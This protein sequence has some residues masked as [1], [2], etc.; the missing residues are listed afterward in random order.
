MNVELQELLD[1]TQEQQDKW[2]RW[3]AEK[4]DAPLGIAIGSGRL[5]NVGEV[6]R[7]AFGV[8]LYFAERLAGKPI[9]RYWETP[10]T[11]TGTLFR[12]AFGAHE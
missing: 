10:L 5:N 2:E 4:G 12:K 3:F 6:V 11:D 7:H 8:N 1:Y 9:T